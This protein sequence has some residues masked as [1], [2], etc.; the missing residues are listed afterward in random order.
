MAE[1]PSVHFPAET[2]KLTRDIRAV[3]DCAT[4]EDY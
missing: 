4:V 3:R 1:I 2:K